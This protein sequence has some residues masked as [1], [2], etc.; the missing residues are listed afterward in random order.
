MCH[1]QSSSIHTGHLT[2]TSSLAV[3]TMMQP[4]LLHCSD[5][6]AELP[7]AW[8]H[9]AN[10]QDQ[11]RKL[12]SPHTGSAASPVAW[13]PEQLSAARDSL[14]H[15]VQCISDGCFECHVLARMQGCT[16]TGGAISS[17]SCISGPPAFSHQPMRRFDLQTSRFLPALVFCESPQRCMN[18]GQTVG[19]QQ[20]CEKPRSPIPCSG[21]FS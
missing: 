3:G 14:L 13:N 21:F 18:K 6:D 1:F 2:S 20:S 19:Q 11:V 8:G 7:S 15:E 9:K 16:R 4:W 10:G 12:V 5:Q 17:F